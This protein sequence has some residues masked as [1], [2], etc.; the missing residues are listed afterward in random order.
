MKIRG[1]QMT[2]QRSSVR[3]RRAFGLASLLACA[4]AVGQENS[5][6]GTAAV[7]QEPIAFSIVAQ[8]MR[9]ALKEFAS[10]SHLQLVYETGDLNSAPP[11][12]PVTGAYTPQAA[13]NRLLANT[14]LNYAFVNDKTVSIR[15]ADA[16]APPVNTA[17]ATDPDSTPRNIRQRR[18]SSS[19]DTDQSQP[20][21]PPA[22][23]VKEVKSDN[24]KHETVTLEE[25]VVVTGSHIRGGV[26]TGSPML[27][28]GKDEIARSGYASLRDVLLDL[29]QNSG[30][31]IGEN[32]TV[33]PY[34]NV[35]NGYAATVNLR[36]LGSN[37]TLVLLNGHRLAP[38]GVG[39]AVDI[40]MIPLSVIDRIEVLTDGASA[41]Y[42]SDAVGGVVNL[43][44]NKRFSGFETDA[45]YGGDTAGDIKE[46]HL[47]Q[48]G[49]HDW[50]GGQLVGTYE[51]YK[52]DPL[53]GS[54]RSFS[55]G[56]L[57]PTFLTPEQRRNSALVYGTQEVS[58]EIA[59]Y[60]S[61]LYSDQHKID[62]NF[63][64]PTAPFRDTVGSSQLAATPG[65]KW[66]LPSN[67]MVDLS[68]TYGRNSLQIA[69]IQPLIDKKQTESSRN[70][71]YGMEIRA[72]GP[73]LDL[74]AGSVKAA[75][76]V[77]ARREE[78]HDQI[79]V[80]GSAP[81]SIDAKRNVIS[82][83]GE[84]S[85]PIVSR[86]MSGPPL[87]REIDVSVAARYDR[88]SDSGSSLTP[89][90]G[91]SWLPVDDLKI[92]GTWGKSFHA[93]DQDDKYRPVNALAVDLPDPQSATRSSEVLAALGG[94]QNLGP[95]KAT[96]FT[97]GADF[98][99]TSIKGLKASVTYFDTKYVDRVGSPIANAFT[100]LVDESLYGRAIQR[101]PSEVFL[102]QILSQA[103]FY[104]YTGAPFS[105]ADVR[106]FIDDRN[107]NLAETRER[108]LDAT[109]SHTWHIAA[110]DVGE[111][112]DVAYLLENEQRVT[113]TA[114][115]FR[116]LNRIFYTPSLRLRAGLNGACGWLSGAVALNF[117]GPYSNNQVVPATQIGS[118]TTVDLQLAAD[119]RKLIPTSMSQGL[120]LSL[121]L[122]NAF[123]KAPPTVGG[124]AGFFVNAPYGYDPANAD[125]IGRFVSLRIQKKW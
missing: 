44:T 23:A 92:R 1:A 47:S 8:S 99:P 64:Q 69:T 123:D 95:E 125:P 108:G 67:W 115:S 4:L 28:I 50:G 52:R 5:P 15:V 46:T 63:T 45:Q 62:V 24:K 32:T 21:T 78:F 112:I 34:G 29:P 54:D 93:P 89:K 14:N 90:L 121:T 118:Y 102:Q 11:A 18:S 48:T 124:S 68:A 22:S 120:R 94:N 81:P 111:N 3:H 101:N 51:Y 2:L 88:Y 60:A 59:G 105:V 104:N 7:I 77:A 79:M 83:Y 75:V 85:I 106:A 30:S 35:S 56:L 97:V 43:I 27:V 122:R 116:L 117:T 119:F 98:T 80:V 87:V 12:P 6:G 110:A 25:V 70:L 41:T 26:S 91:L 9:R 38:T 39:G 114:P 74:P 16:S 76:G 96:T 20:E 13:L 73:T 107:L 103:T 72:D 61:V 109:I 84:L 42:G 65:I 113:D 19:V 40:S 71:S 10:Q 82:G 37:A 55:S 57:E 49:G 53:L 31:G 58:N 33:V 86:A 66:A 17:L 100:A 36:G